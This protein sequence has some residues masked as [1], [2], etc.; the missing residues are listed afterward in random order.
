MMKT[1]IYDLVKDCNNRP[2]LSV[3]RTIECCSNITCSKDVYELVVPEVGLDRMYEEYVFLLALNNAGCP[4]G[5]FCVAHGSASG[6]FSNIQG[7]AIRL[8]LVGA[9]SFI[10]VHNHPSGRVTLS[11]E[12]YRTFKTLKSLGALLEVK[13]L[14]YIVVGNGY[15][16]I[17]DDEKL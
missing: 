7:I 4:V 15:Y 14:D 8:L 9:S 6:S 13:L 1:Y 10:V 17:A 5:I 11:S 2:E 12:D 3:S 16:S